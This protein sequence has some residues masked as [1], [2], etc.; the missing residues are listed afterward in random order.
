[1]EPG[2][3]LDKGYGLGGYP[4]KPAELESSSIGRIWILETPSLWRMRSMIFRR[5]DAVRG[6][7]IG[8][9]ERQE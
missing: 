6:C 4:A 8:G 9:F 2:A 3:L 5:R 1:M 7:L